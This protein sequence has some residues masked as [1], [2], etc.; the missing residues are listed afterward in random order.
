MKQ[1]FSQ[2]NIK[3]YILCIDCLGNNFHIVSMGYYDSN[4][5]DEIFKTFANLI[6]IATNL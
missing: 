6:I 2:H 4:K 3:K 1:F 5:I